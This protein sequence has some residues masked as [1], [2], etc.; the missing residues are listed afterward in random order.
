LI[1][2]AKK[3]NISAES[4]N[5]LTCSVVKDVLKVSRSVTMHLQLYAVAVQ[6]N[7]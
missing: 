2:A 5:T 3:I 6:M 7:D 4:Q 1:R